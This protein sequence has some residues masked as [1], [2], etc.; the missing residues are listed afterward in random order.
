MVVNI[1]FNILIS[2]EFCLFPNKSISLYCDVGVYK[3]LPRQPAA[4][5]DAIY[6]IKSVMLL[7]I[8]KPEPA[9]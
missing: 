7:S 6:G 2:I 4:S 9:V 3:R 1:L 5:F 8:G